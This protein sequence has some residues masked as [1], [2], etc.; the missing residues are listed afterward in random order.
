MKTLKLTNAELGML[1][2][3]LGEFEYCFLEG[4]EYSGYSKA[5]VKAFY[6]LREKVY[7]TPM[8]DINEVWNEQS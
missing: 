8:P 5:R 4:W 7:G 3:A 6:Q 2:A 1:E